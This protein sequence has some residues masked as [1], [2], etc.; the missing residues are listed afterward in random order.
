MQAIFTLVTK[1]KRPE[2]SHSEDYHRFVALTHELVEPARIS[3]LSV[4]ARLGPI[5]VKGVTS[6]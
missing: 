6:P 2:R 3:R 5:G 4:T 1:T